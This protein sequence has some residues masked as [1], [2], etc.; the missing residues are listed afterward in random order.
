MSLERELAS[1]PLHA[2]HAQLITHA[3]RLLPREVRA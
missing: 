2:A 1:L 3:E